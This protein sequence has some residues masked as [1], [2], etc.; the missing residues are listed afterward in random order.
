MRRGGRSCA[1]CERGKSS[2]VPVQQKPRFQT[3]SDWLKEPDLP[4]RWLIE[5]W[6][7]EGSRVLTFAQF[8]AGKTTLISNLLRSIADGDLFLAQA[9]TT[10]LKQ[11]ET[12]V[13][14]D[15]AMSPPQLQ[16]GTVEQG[17]QN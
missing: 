8:K 6:M 10:P 9:I 2:V 16:E 7:H 12:A 5:E 1:S 4:M 3:L 15:F 17:I 14:L 13:L 11:G